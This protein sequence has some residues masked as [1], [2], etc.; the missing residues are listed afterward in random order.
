M[1]AGRG[2]ATGDGLGLGAFGFLVLTLHS[3]FGS[4]VGAGN[5]V[6]G[7]PGLGIVVRGGFG[8]GFVGDVPVSP[9]FFFAI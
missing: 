5:S 3:D 4:G 1:A 9:S 7:T 2:R 6:L 8:R